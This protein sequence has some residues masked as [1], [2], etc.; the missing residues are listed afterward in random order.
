MRLADGSQERTSTGK[1][2]RGCLP[3]P[4]WKRRARRVDYLPYA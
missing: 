2:L 1:G 4:G 3:V